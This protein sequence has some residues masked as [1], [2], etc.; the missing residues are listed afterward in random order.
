ML[1]P[2]QKYVQPAY[3][4]LLTALLIAPSGCITDIGPETC[5]RPESDEPTVYDGGS[6]VGGTYSTSDW[7]SDLLPFPG[8]AYYEL[9]HQLG[10]TPQLVQVYLSFGADGLADGSI[11]PAAGNQAEIKAID[12]EKIVLLNGTCSDSYVLVVATVFGGAGGAG[13]G[14][15]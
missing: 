5:P 13:G 7:D 15:P 6:T 10:V 4:A 3:G 14:G 2:V 12:D 8:G 1:R 11:A 9:R